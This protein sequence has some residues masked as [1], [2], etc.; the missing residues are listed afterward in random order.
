MTLVHDLHGLASRIFYFSMTA[1][2]FAFISILMLTAH[3]P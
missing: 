1:S 3:H 2:V